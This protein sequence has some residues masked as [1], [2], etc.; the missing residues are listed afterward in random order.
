MLS[1][2]CKLMKM[3]CADGVHVYILE[4]GSKVMLESRDLFKLQKRGEPVISE[5]T[6]SATFAQVMCFQFH[7]DCLRSASAA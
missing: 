7:F 4:A 3:D 1:I 2:V 5:V 6:V